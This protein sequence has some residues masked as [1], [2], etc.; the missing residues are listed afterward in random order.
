MVRSVSIGEN[1]MGSDGII[2]G[3]RWLEAKR[4]LLMYDVKR[5]V[6]QSFHIYIQSSFPCERSLIVK[7]YQYRNHQGLVEVFTQVF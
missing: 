2:G 3:S 5:R 1:S 7:R 4:F 6:R